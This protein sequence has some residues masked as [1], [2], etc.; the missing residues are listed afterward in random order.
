MDEHGGHE[1]GGLQGRWLEVVADGAGEGGP[2]RHRGCAGAVVQMV[3]AVFAQTAD[4][5]GPSRGRRVSS[6][7]DPEA[8]AVRGERVEEELE[9]RGKRVKTRV[10]FI[11][12]KLREGGSKIRDEFVLLT[13]SI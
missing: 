5:A 7:A 3:D 13:L 12:D 6:L 11:D 8:A 2:R 10:Q 9:L 4:V 1:V